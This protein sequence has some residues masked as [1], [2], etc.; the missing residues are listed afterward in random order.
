MKVREK[1]VGGDLAASKYSLNKKIPFNVAIPC[2]E[3][4]PADLFGQGY[5]DVNIHCSTPCSSK[6]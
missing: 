3:I 2:L 4:D 6:R 1:Y 5:K